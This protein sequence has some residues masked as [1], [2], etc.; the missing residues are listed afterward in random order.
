MGDYRKSINEAAWLPK[1]K[2]ISLHQKRLGRWSWQR[3]VTGCE[4][5]R[6]SWSVLFHM[7]QLPEGWVNDWTWYMDHFFTVNF[8]LSMQYQCM[9]STCSFKTQN[10]FI[11]PCCK[12]PKN[13]IHPFHPF[14]LGRA[15]EVAAAKLQVPGLAASAEE[16]FFIRQ[17]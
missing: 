17:K 10:H 15:V 14:R 8:C 16:F 11:A 1:S 9:I 7:A 5:L 6:W 13:P 4:T 2:V 12:T 3:V